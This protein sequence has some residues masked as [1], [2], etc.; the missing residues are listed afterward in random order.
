MFFTVIYGKLISGKVHCT[1]HRNGLFPL[2]SSLMKTHFVYEVKAC[3]IQQAAIQNF[4]CWRIF[5]YHCSTEAVTNAL[6]QRLMQKFRPLQKLW[7]TLHN[8]LGFV[9]VLFMETKDYVIFF[10]LVL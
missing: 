2:T 1:K 5:N 9:A 7:H 6:T 4:L 10:S 8:E 3:K